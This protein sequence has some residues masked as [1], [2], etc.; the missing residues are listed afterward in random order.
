MRAA[1]LSGLTVLAT[2][3]L[4]ARVPAAENKTPVESSDD[5]AAIRA[6][7]DNYVEAYNRRDSRTMASMWS[8]EAVYMDPTSGER[9]V[10]REAIAKHFDDVFAGQQDAKLALKQAIAIVYLG[11]NV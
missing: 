9:F 6:N 3:A 4:A 2:I 10:G 5:E 7:V 8:P 1:R 11:R